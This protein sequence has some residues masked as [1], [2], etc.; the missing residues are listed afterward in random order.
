MQHS[1]RPWFLGPM[2]A[3]CGGQLVTM[4]RCCG[5]AGRVPPISA[6]SGQA[7]TA[8]AASDALRACLYPGSVVAFSSRACLV[9]AKSHSQKYNSSLQTLRPCLSR[10][11]FCSGKRV[12]LV[13]PSLRL[14]GALSVTSVG[15]ASALGLH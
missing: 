5:V 1:A 11:S 7:R 10:N 9:Q 3:P 2:V 14:L 6:A 12:L 13:I 15:T 8:S 4:G